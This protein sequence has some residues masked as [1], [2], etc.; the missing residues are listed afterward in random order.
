MAA[1]KINWRLAH[2]IATAI[3][4]KAFDHLKSPLETELEKFADE[5]YEIIVPG[6]KGKALNELQLL[7]A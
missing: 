5:A 4:D 3:A 7:V 6:I 2:N 1:K